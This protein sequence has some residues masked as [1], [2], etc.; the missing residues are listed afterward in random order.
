[1]NEL[2]VLVREYVLAYF[3]PA[4]ICFALLLCIEAGYESSDV[5][6]HGDRP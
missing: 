6:V 1:M 2:A 5:A 4:L 3:F